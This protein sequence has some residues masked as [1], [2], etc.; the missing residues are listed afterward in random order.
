MEPIKK[1]TQFNIVYFFL[2]I[3]VIMIIQDMWMKHKTITH[4]PYNEF[5]KELK[6][7]NISE[8]IITENQ[9]QGILKE[10]INNRKQF[11]T[12][13]VEADLVKEL[14]TQNVKYSRI[15]ENTFFKDILSWVIPVFIFL[16]IWMFLMKRMAAKGGGLTG[17]FMSVGK[18]K[19]KV[20]VESDTKTSFNDVAGVDEAKEELNEVVNFL[21][22]PIKS[23]SLLWILI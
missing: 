12:T 21:R 10:P 23:Q 13:R 11:S 14:E 4:I 18:S 9:L 8:I 6:S 17:G 19:A 2:A 22:D 15:I 20:Y 3:I 7:G 5:R 1:E 16:A